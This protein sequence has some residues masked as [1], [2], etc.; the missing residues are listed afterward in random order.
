MDFVIS[1]SDYPNNKISFKYFDK[2]IQKKKDI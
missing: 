2:H 1:N